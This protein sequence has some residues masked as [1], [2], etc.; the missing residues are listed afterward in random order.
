MVCR[1]DVTGRTKT[2]MGRGRDDIDA[3]KSLSI[4]LQQAPFRGMF[5][6][7]SCHAPAAARQR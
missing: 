3:A 5:A 1:E 6:E 2:H 7:W 4:A